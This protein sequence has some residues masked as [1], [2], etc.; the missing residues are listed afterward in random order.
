MDN[1]SEIESFDLSSDD[2]IEELMKKN[3]SYPDL[4]DNEIQKKLY[5]KKEFVYNSISERPDTSVY[6]NIKEYRDNICGRPFSLYE[7][8]TLLSNFINPDTPYKGIIVFHGLGTGKCVGMNTKVIVNSHKMTIKEVFDTFHTELDYESHI[9]SNVV[10]SNPSCDLFIKSY[11]TSTNRIVTKKIAKLYREQVNTIVRKIKFEDGIELI[12]TDSHRLYRNNGL[13]EQNLLVGDLIGKMSDN[14]T[15]HFNRIESIERIEYNDFVYDFEIAD[16]HNYFAEGILCHNTCV[17]ISIAEKF[18]PMVL[19]YNTKIIILVGGPLIKENWKKSAVSCTGDTYIKKNTEL[20]VSNSERQKEEKLALTQVLQYYKFMSYKSFYKHVIGEKMKDVHGDGKAKYRKTEEGEFER[21]ISVDRIHNLNNTVIIVDEAHN[22]TGNFY[23]DALKLIIKN[24]FNLKVVLLTGTPMKNIGS[25]IVDLLNFI[26]P[27]NSQ[28]EKDK[29]FTNDRGHLIDF[30][31]GGFDYLKNMMKGY[32]SH[33]R[34]GDPLIFAKRVDKG[35]IPTDLLFTKVISCYMS[36]FQKEVYDRAIKESMDSLDRSSE[37]V[38]NFVFPGLSEDKSKLIGYFANE[39]LTFVKNQLNIDGKIINKKLSQL[40]YGNDKETDL[41]SVSSNGTITGKILKM[42]YLKIFSTKFAKALKKISRLVINKKGPKTAFIYSNLVTVG[43]SVFHEILIQN[44]YLEYQEEKEN[45]Q[46][47]NDTI[48]YYC[49]KTYYEHLNINLNKKII[50][51]TTDITYTTDTDTNENLEESTLNLI[52]ETSAIEKSDNLI[53]ESTLNLI[54][55]TSNIASASDKSTIPKISDSSSE[56]DKV[57][58]DHTHMFYPATFVTI[59][60][61][62]NEETLDALP[63]DKKRILDKVFSIPENKEGKFIKFILGSRVMNEGI[64]LRQVGEVHILDAYYNF[65]RIDQVIGRGIR[66]CS[67]YKLMSE[68][69]V[70]PEVNV[71]KYV[72]SLKDK[73]LSTEELLY[74][75]AELKYMLIKKIERMMK[76]IAIDCPLMTNGNIFKEEVEKYKDCVVGKD[77]PAICDYQKCD[78]KCDDKVLNEKYYDPERNI[79]KSVPKHSLD[80]TTFTHGL[81]RTEINNAKTKIKDMYLF[82]YNYK[83]FEIIDYVKSSYDELK[84]E[85]FDEFFVYKA[86]EELIPTTENDFNNF[87]DVIVDK[88]NR[89]GYLIYVEDNY[90]FQPFD[91]NENVPMYY[92]TTITHQLSNELSLYNYLKSM[93]QYDELK[94]YKQEEEE[95]DIVNISLY[96]FDSVMQYYEDR[97]EYDIVGIIDK[98]VGRS[99]IK[100]TE[101]TPDTFKIREKR[102]K[103]LDKK[104]GINIQSFFGSVCTTKDKTYLKKILKKIDGSSKASTKVTMCDAL[105]NKLLLLEKY[106]T[107]KNKDKFTYVII[108]ANHKE[109]PFPYNLEDR[110]ELLT[111]KIHKKIDDKITISTTSFNKTSGPEKGYPS[112]TVSISSTKL[113]S[114]S[115]FLTDL[116]FKKDGSKFVITI[117]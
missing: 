75:K 42:Q 81:A 88:Y 32:I 68:D 7:H 105:K 71:Y 84:Y 97:Q 14:G 108:P 57:M 99:K 77:C 74:Q 47:T 91:Q 4:T 93:P 96:D 22:L 112:Y 48:C 102:P 10:W 110:I 28:I 18:K 46:I 76:E 21:D 63:E 30:K 94:T 116:G 41:I 55:E 114:H 117:G 35:V 34:G 9:N 37:A 24:S 26:R 43:I 107:A 19:K 98:D 79:Y 54:D 72:I 11:M 61:K 58:S 31:Q 13:W 86:L 5:E 49:G 51:D 33:V 65:T 52:D 111:E 109:Y 20:I 27:L 1:T 16:T 78:Y 8:Q 80:M 39:G 113:N 36:D 50:T 89:E 12:I 44:G 56:Y 87:K 70:Y 104:R 23:G 29:I 38:A 45:Y 69:N 106:G 6:A 67:H 62:S 100:I 59:T 66:N 53:E 60:G 25:D 2:N 115:N 73:T 3:Y 17:G 82:N 15:L 95:K 103:I 40:L 85:L 64:N 83:L 101:D 92:R 90:I